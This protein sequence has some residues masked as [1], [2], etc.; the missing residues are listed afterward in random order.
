MKS[1]FIESNDESDSSL[2]TQ[3][4]FFQLKSFSV[5]L[6]NLSKTLGHILFFLKSKNLSKKI[7]HILFFLKSNKKKN[8]YCCNI[9]ITSGPDGSAK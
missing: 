9:I 1:K 8:T 2:L 6:K 4:I 3:T 5:K 7:C